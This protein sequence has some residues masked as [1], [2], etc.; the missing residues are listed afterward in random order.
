MTDLKDLRLS[1]FE[2]RINELFV[3]KLP[4][5]ETYNLK[6]IAVRLLGVSERDIAAHGRESFSLTFENE[7]KNVYLQ[8]GTYALE[9]EKLGVLNLFIVPL[10]PSPTGMQ[11]EVIFT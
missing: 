11:Y 5:N 4:D 10:G 3:V 7:R 6:L 9:N 1:D 2:E 8:Q